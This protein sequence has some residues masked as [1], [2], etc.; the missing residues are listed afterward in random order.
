MFPFQHLNYSDDICL[1]LF[2]F[3]PSLAW[4]L[5]SCINNLDA[6]VIKMSQKH[7]NHPSSYPLESVQIE[8]PPNNDSNMLRS[9]KRNSTRSTPSS[10]GR[11]ERTASRGLM[12]LRF[13]DRTLTGKEENAWREIE[14]RFNQFAINGKLSKEKF[15]IC[16]G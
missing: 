9:T 11:M 13:L 2:C 7:E 12:S 4:V 10:S 3:L 8:S 6:F 14:M 5:L 15:G 16:I 1:F